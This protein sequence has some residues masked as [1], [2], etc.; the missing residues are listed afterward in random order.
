MNK[1]TFTVH[2]W[3]FKKPVTITLNGKY[4]IDEKLRRLLE[5]EMRRLADHYGENEDLDHVSASEYDFAADLK[6]AYELILSGHRRYRGVD[7]HTVKRATGTDGKGNNVYKV[8]RTE[9]VPWSEMLRMDEVAA[10]GVEGARK[11]R[12]IRLLG[13]D[14]R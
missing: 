3:C 9:R 12:R 13:G 11:R 14:A 10:Y 5:L 4:E 1:T 7:L 8:L 6:T 2:P